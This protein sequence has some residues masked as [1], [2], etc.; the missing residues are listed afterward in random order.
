LKDNLE[1][2]KKYPELFI[3]EFRHLVL[4]LKKESAEDKGWEVFKSY[5]TEVHNNFDNKTKAI[6]DGISEKEYI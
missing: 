3:I 2:I 6:A 4:H 5:F 1:K